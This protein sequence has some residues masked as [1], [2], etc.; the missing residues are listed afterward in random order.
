MLM[1]PG[2]MDGGFNRA[3]E[4]RMDPGLWMITDPALFIMDPS[5]G[6]VYASINPSKGSV[7]EK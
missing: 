6:S 5:K 7:L 2:F 3:S 4:L 1:E